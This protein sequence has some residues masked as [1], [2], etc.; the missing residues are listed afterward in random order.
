[1]SFR[2]LTVLS[3]AALAAMA[4]A[5]AGCGGSA[6]KAGSSQTAASGGDAATA[7]LVAKADRICLGLNRELEAAKSVIRSQADIV[8]IAPRRVALEGKALSRLSAL[9]PPPA[10]ANDYEQ[11]LVARRTLMED[12]SKLAAYAVAKHAQTDLFAASAGMVRNMATIAQRDGYS[13]CGRV[14]G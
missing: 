2:V 6:G 4:I 9:T 12:T 7:Q 8:R 3:G 14:G 1:M 5:I 11:L 13:D 10:I